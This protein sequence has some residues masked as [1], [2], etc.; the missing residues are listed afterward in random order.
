M[1]GK[2]RGQRHLASRRLFRMRSG[3]KRKWIKN[4]NLW[5]V[6]DLLVSGATSAAAAR[7]LRQ[8]HPHCVDLVVANV[9][10]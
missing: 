8:L 1:A 5:I 9:R 6:D 7:L 3:E 10:N 4:S 2:S